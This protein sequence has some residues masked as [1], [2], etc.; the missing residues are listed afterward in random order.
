MSQAK[1][2]TFKCE[3]VEAST[4]RRF[5]PTDSATS[6]PVLA[7]LESVLR[8][9]FTVLLQEVSDPGLI[10]PEYSRYRQHLKQ[11]HIRHSLTV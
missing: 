10:E 3:Y 11:F 9:Q 1:P 4:H 6:Q 8:S 7:L 2:F 5:N